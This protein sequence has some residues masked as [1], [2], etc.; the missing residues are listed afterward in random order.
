MKIEPTQEAA[1]AGGYE[2]IIID[3]DAGGYRCYLPGEIVRPDIPTTPP[4]VP[5]LAFRKALSE[6]G[7]RQAVEDYVQA[8]PLDIRDEW[9]QRQ[10]C[11]YDNPLIRG[12]ATAL[13]V[14]DEQFAVLWARC[15]QIAAEL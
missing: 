5:M 15:V 2:V 1:E 3:P 6:A 4:P 10:T 8:A 9:A 12:A 11:A 14:T 7:L 13:G